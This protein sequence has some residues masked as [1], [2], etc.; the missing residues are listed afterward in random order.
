M[1]CTATGT[2]CVVDNMALSSLP[3]SFFIRCSISALSVICV[4]P[5]LSLSRFPSS[6]SEFFSYHTTMFLQQLR[7]GIC[8]AMR[9]VGNL[10]RR[11]VKIGHSVHSRALVNQEF[12][13]TAVATPDC[14]VQ[15][16]PSIA[17]EC[18]QQRLVGIKS[19]SQLVQLPRPVLH[20]VRLS[21]RWCL[22]H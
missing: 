3:V 2:V 15:W 16:S 5:F 6:H 13:N 21:N 11:L 14:L 18:L 9:T 7:D 1:T 10:Q 12:D 20:D 19:L 22:P 4:Y 17:V 8:I